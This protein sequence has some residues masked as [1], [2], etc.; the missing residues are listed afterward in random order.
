VKTAGTDALLAL[1]LAD[2]KAGEAALNKSPRVNQTVDET[3]ALTL[4][5]RFDAATKKQPILQLRDAPEY[6]MES[7]N[8]RLHQLETRIL[9]RL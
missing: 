9:G 4:V 8:R 1:V 2:Q 3:L 7:G 6:G 5:E